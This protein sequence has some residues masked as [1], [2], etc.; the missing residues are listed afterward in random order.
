MRL[1]LDDVDGLR[2]TGHGVGWVEINGERHSGS[3]V[4]GLEGVE[5][6]GES[7]G[8][9]DDLGEG[10]KVIRDAVSQGPAVVLVGTGAAFSMVPPWFIGAFA[11]AGAGVESMDTSAACRTYNVLAGEGRDVVAFL[12]QGGQAD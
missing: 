11:G 4:I 2:V 5:A 3:V 1:H 6:L 8:S 7:V 10:H 9:V 12:F